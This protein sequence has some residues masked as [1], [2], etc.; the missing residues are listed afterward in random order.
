MQRRWRIQDGWVLLCIVYTYAPK[1]LRDK[2]FV[3]VHCMHAYTCVQK[4]F[5]STPLYL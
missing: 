3:I 1:W 2:K 5:S 4:I